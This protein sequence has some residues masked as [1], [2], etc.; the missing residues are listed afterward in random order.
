MRQTKNFFLYNLSITQAISAL[1]LSPLK[2]SLVNVF[3]ERKF[4][5]LISPALRGFTSLSK[6]TSCDLY[7]MTQIE[8]FPKGVIVIVRA[9]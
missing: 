4:S 1:C 6:P 9:C 5:Q 8:R 2:P 3:H 7:G